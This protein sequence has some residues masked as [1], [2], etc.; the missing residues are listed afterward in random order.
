MWHK[1]KLVFGI[2]AV[3]VILFST[4]CSIRPSRPMTFVDLDHYQINCRYK[5]QQIAMLQSMRP[6]PDDRL[7]ARIENALNPFSI[8]TD[9]DQ[10]LDRKAVSAGRT[11]WLL[12]QKL[13]AL[14]DDC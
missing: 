3:S 5:T 13:M 10:Y 12:N 7:F 8:I 2:C 6:T 14:R 4:G 9:T 1:S 11:E